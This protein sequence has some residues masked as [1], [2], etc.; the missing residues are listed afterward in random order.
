VNLKLSLSFFPLLEDEHR[1]L[2][3]AGGKGSGKS[4]FAARKLF[5]R[6]KNEGGHRFLVLRKVRKTAHQSTLEVFRRLLAEQE[7]E[8]THDKTHQIISFPAT[9]GQPN[10]LLFDGLDEPEKI[11]SIKALTGVWIEE[12]TEFT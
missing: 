11:K 4:E 12:A 9:N 7:I 6:C 1:Y 2:V 10:E 3:L 8:Y 5:V